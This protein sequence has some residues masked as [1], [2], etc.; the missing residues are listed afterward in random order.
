MKAAVKKGMG[1]TLGVFKGNDLVAAGFFGKD[2]KR[3]YYLMGAPSKTGREMKAIHVL[4]DTVI[5]EYA[6]SRLIFDFEGSDIPNVYNFYRKFSP[7]TK[8]YPHL[9]INRL[10]F[11]LRWLKS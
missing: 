8:Y 11:F 3:I 10:P 9:K 7:F 4:V 5:R 2:E 6:G 1:F